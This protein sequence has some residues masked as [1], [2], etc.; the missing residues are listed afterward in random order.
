MVVVGEHYGALPPL[1]AFN[2]GTNRTS[3]P[4]SMAHTVYIIEYCE[5]YVRILCRQYNFWKQSAPVL[6]IV[7]ARG[8]QNVDVRRC[9]WRGRNASLFLIK[10]IFLFVSKQLWVRYCSSYDRND[11]VLKHRRKQN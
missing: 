1:T 5:S 11:C 4:I 8:H 9:Q 3:V 7:M 2:S 6:N 10:H